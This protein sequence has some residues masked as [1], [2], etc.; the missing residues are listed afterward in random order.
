[1]HEQT[2]KGFNW[3]TPIQVAER[4]HS[5]MTKVT[6]MHQSRTNVEIESKDCTNNSF[7]NTHSIPCACSVKCVKLYYESFLNETIAMSESHVL[8]SFQNMCMLLGYCLKRVNLCF[9]NSAPGV[10][11]SSKHFIYIMFY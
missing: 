5:R 8:I 3:V 7:L 11:F 10:I 1:M 9:P 2:A 4:V 6:I